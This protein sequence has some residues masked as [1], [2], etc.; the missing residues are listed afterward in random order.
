M[1]YEILLLNVSRDLGGLS[2]AFRDSIGQ[3]SIAS[4]LR[5]RD[6]KAYVY[7]GNINNCQKIIKHELNN[8]KTNVIG[9]YA[10]ADNI[11]VV[12]N[13]ISWIKKS[14]PQCITIVGGPQVAG[15]DYEF[16]NKTGNDYAII[17]EGEIPIYMLL[18]YL[19]DGEGEL[20]FIP[21]LI[22]KDKYEKQLIINSSNGA[23]VEDLDSIDFPR[24]VDSY[25]G[26]LRQGDVV[27]IITGR[28]CPNQCA[29][30]YEG[31]NAKNVRFRSISNVMSEIDYIRNHNHR[32]SF[33]S[34]YD[35]TFTLNKKRI[36]EFCDEIEKR[37]V[38][39][40]CEG[41]IAFVINQT[42]VLKRMIE[43]GL[44]CIQFGI[45]SGS[46]LVLNAYNKH[47]NFDMIVKAIKICKSLGIHSITG[48][49][50]IGGAH[51][52]KD[53][54]EQSK[55][56][57]K[58]LINEAKGIIELYT[59]YFAPYPNTRMVREP[60]DY[61][62]NIYPELQERNL[63]TMRTPVVRTKELS[64]NQIYDAKHEFDA[65]LMNE[66]K[67]AAMNSTKEDVMQGM[68]QNGKIIHLNPTWEKFYNSMPHISNFL[69][70]ITEME[71]KFNQSFFIIRTFEDYKI[72][73]GI[74]IADMGTFEG[75]E[76]ELLQDATGILTARD[77]AEKYHVSME[78]IEMMYHKLNDRCLVYMSQF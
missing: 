36:L 43:A 11:R 15:L 62:I 71:Q 30:C 46:D 29:F 40:F 65:F 18:S 23:I 73:D 37:K 17:G 76:Q 45:E 63:N 32:L 42:D 38:T 51:E 20:E 72:V 33:I 35:D 14:Y 8:H 25:N 57:A 48:N 75:L 64:V 28:G 9:F 7:S 5:Q 68:V 41:H 54:L 10:A 70:H 60:E 56:I 16:F 49:F 77:M 59:V 78:E 47:T 69:N 31:A 52:S 39:W 12:S 22:R 26:R 19:I 2:E 21:S 13:V 3:Y 67:Q 53:T 74:M 24:E 1:D 50:I 6:F 66:Y 44:S 58:I 34:I 27:G 55:K 4:Y 61:G